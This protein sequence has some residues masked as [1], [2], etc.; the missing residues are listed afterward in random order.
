M[1]PSSSTILIALGVCALLCV[2]CYFFF[3]GGS[4]QRDGLAQQREEG[5]G[6]AIMMLFSADWCPY[7]QRMKPEWDKLVA[8]TTAPVNGYVVKFVK[9]DCTDKSDPA[10]VKKMNEFQVDGWPTVK[11]IV[12]KQTLTFD[13]DPTEDNL[14]E[15]IEQGTSNA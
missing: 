13:A 1:T 3:G 7:C 6:E 4:R 11:L 5:K 15:F 8:D 2:V 12:G 10:V 9:I 14:K